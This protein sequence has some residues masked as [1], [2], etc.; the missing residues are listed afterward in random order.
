MTVSCAPRVAARGNQGRTKEIR[1][2]TASSLYLWKTS[3]ETILTGR[4][5]RFS[6][7]FFFPPSQSGN[8]TLTYE[9][10]RLEANSQIEEIDS[11]ICS[12]D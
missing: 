10:L 9:Q 4:K 11:E 7:V 6:Q 5:M 1:I 8:Q 2:K 3:R 12:E